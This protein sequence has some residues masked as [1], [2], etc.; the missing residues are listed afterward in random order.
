MKIF[1]MYVQ[2]KLYFLPSNNNNKKK[3][4]HNDS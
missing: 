4:Q 3:D 1:K 2:K